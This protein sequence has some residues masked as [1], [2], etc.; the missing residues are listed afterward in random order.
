MG[1]DGKKIRPGIN[2]V[3]IDELT[4]CNSMLSAQRKKRQ[5]CIFGPYQSF[6]QGPEVFVCQTWLVLVNRKIDMYISEFTYRMHTF[7][8]GLHRLYANRI[9]AFTH[10]AIVFVE[11]VH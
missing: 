1:P 10:L 7:C 2:P 6:K 8:I 9:V 11:M 4:E 5:V 3:M